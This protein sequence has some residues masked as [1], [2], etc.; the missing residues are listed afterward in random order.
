MTPSSAVWHQLGSGGQEDPRPAPSQRTWPHWRTLRSLPPGLSW[1]SRCL[2]LALAY[3]AAA[4]IGLAYSSLAPNVTLIWAPTGVALFAILRWGP[5][6]WPAIVLGDAIANAGTGATWWAVAGI[7][8]G[9]VAQS[10]ACARA[11]RA[12]GFQPDLRRI[13]DVTALLSLGTAGAAISATIGPAL[14]MAGGSFAPVMYPSVWLQWLMGDATGVLVVTPLLLAWWPAGKVRSPSPGTGGHREAWALLAVLAA[15]CAAIF[16]WQGERPGLLLPGHYPSAMALFPL[17]IWAALRFGLRGATLLTLAVSV[18][19]VWG[20][21]RGIGPFVDGTLTSSLLR[22]WLFANL[23]TVTTLLLSA[24]QSERHE[25]QLEAIRDRDFTTAILD[26]EGALVV[27]LDEGWRIVRVNRALESLT[28]FA[29]ADLVGHRF[30]EMLLPREQHDRFTGHAE[31]LRLNLKDTARHD[32]TLRRRRGPPLTVS[33]TMS[34]LR[35]DRRRPAHVIV[36]GVDVSTRVEAAAALRVARRQLADRV[37]QRTRELADANAD[38]KVQMAERQRLEREIIA[39]GEDA[40]RHVGQELHDGLG[41]HL[42][43]AAIQAELL[44]RDLALAGPDDAQTATQAQARRIE[45]MISDAIDQTRSLAHGLYPV[46]VDAAGLMAALTRLADSVRHDIRRPC[47]LDCPEPVTLDEHAVALH[48]YRIAQEA[49][50]NALKHAPE[51]ALWMS[52]RRRPGRLELQIRNALATIPRQP[53]AV[54]SDDDRIDGLGL[55]I[56]RHRARLIGATLHVGPQ[57]QHWRVDLRLP[58]SDIHVRD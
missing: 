24:S 14:L 23:L 53:A 28:G 57:D 41:Q 22:W 2:L 29:R 55:R 35:D 54:P 52:L 36:S 39:I 47:E 44:A 56:M 17:A 3:G 30:D 32:G 27:V 13:R 58:D 48:L 49:V 16:G 20:T 9:N 38:L 40:L 46:E 33:W 45:R 5:G 25:A 42:T 7:A 51:G 37:D 1:L 19:A 11:L 43:A 4:R 26:A 10:L 18:A 31:L 6:L 8:L 50:N 15:L 34:V 21:V 12:S